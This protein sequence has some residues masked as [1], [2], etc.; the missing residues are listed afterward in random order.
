MSLSLHAYGFGVSLVLYIS[1]CVYS[2]SWCVYSI[3]ECLF[4]F[5]FERAFVFPETQHRVTKEVE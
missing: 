3:S 4:E 5:Y 1:W 2:I